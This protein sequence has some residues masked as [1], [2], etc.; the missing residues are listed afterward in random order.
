MGKFTERAAQHNAQGTGGGD[1]GSSIREP[2][3]N[4]SSKGTNNS[5]NG[6]AAGSSATVTSVKSFNQID[7]NVRRDLEELKRVIQ[8]LR[9]TS[10]ELQSPNISPSQQNKLLNKM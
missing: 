4:S 1:R 7:S 2:L 9:K 8:H 3:L 10:K 5:V 6:A